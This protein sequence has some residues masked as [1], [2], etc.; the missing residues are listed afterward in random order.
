MD[1]HG[2][3]RG[4]FLGLALIP[5]SKNISLQTEKAGAGKFRHPLIFLYAV[6]KGG[7]RSQLLTI[8]LFYDFWEYKQTARSDDT[9]DMLHLPYGQFALQG[10]RPWFVNILLQYSKFEFYPHSEQ[11]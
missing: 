10:V 5:T 7:F 1:S 11:E 9:D 2:C 3:Q 8:I 4:N 6:F